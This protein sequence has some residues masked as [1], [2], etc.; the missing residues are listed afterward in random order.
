ML[1]TFLHTVKNFI[2]PTIIKVTIPVF[3][4]LLQLS[5]NGAFYSTDPYEFKPKLLKIFYDSLMHT[6]GVKM[7]DHLQ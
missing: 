6:N 5:P 4:L 3:Y 1:P 7:I 2:K